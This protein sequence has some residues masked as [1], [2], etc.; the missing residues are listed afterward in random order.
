MSGWPGPPL[1]HLKQ[2]VEAVAA[3]RISSRTTRSL[4]GE[5]SAT[6]RKRRW[7]NGISDKGK[8]REMKK[9]EKERRKKN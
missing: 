5:A 7:V 3:G 6:Q 4:D 9:I 1:R 8:E 2:D